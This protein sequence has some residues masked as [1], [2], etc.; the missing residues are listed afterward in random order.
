MRL[1]RFLFAMFLRTP[2]S[3]SAILRII[4]LRDSRRKFQAALR[5]ED[6]DPQAVLCARCGKKV[7]SEFDPKQVMTAGYYYVGGEA[8]GWADIAGTKPGED[9]LCDACMWAT[10]GYIKIYGITK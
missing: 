9:F 7:D 8:N 5:G 2:Q 10:P 6:V 1:V 4:L 3:R